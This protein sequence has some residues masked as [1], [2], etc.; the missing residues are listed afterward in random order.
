MSVQSNCMTEINSQTAVAEKKG[1]IFSE[2]LS[3]VQLVQ[4]LAE[5]NISIPTEIQ[6]RSIPVV[7]AGR[8]LI[9]QAQTGSGK[10]LAFLLPLVEK[11]RGVTNITGT[12]AL[13]LTP[14][15]ELA[16]QIQ[17]V[18]AL[19]A[20]EIKPVC[21]IG[22][23]SAR[24]QTDAL[25]EDRRVVIGT[26]GRVL[27]LLKQRVF[28][29]R[30]CRYFVL[31]EADEM[32][33]MGF[34]DDVRAILS[35]LPDKRQ[36]LFFSATISPRVRML[37]STFLS[38]PE[39]VLVNSGSESAPEIVHRYCQVGSGLTEKV[40]V[41][42]DLIE[43]ERPRS[44][45]IFCNTRSDTEMVEAFLRRRGFDARRINSDLSQSQ[46]EAIMQA[47][48]SGELRLL[49][50]TDVAARGI[51]IEQI[52]LV[53]NYS[54]H[55]TPEVY[56]HR[57]GRT[58]RAGRAGKA[59]SIVGPQDFEGFY[60]LSKKLTIDLEQMPIPSEQQVLEARLTH[61][62]EL[63]RSREVKFA[64]KELN[65]AKGILKDLADIEDPAIELV[66]LMAKLYAAFVAS[67]VK[68]ESV[69][70]SQE[71]GDRSVGEANSGNR[72]GGSRSGRDRSSRG[73]VSRG[74]ASRGQ[75]S[76]EQDSS[77]HGSRSEAGRGR[78]SR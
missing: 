74:Q 75:A 14:T 64:E 68:P 3:D 69:E 28:V 8:D 72:Q 54:L 22:G 6:A 30:S 9:A 36:G 24:A 67:A 47:L 15:R 26:P 44:S 4:V 23:A 27:D 48:R 40:N 11:L 59:I 78:R 42:C 43:T 18:M 71:L 50:A 29:L 62:Y 21:V 52:D 34:I 51:D 25:Q 45:V 65:I 70:L 66:E 10:T 32:L 7:R 63:V 49:I 53:V 35:R 46:R 39:E 58:G 77:G 1:E 33:S 16:V 31:D 37:A 41:L 73:P 17:N 20:P 12:Y 13:I 76:R 57:T 38:D 55:E 60:A 2:L 61:F 5:Q 19:L 56:L